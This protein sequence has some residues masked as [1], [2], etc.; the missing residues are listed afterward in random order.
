MEK[1]KRKRLN[2]C[3]D[4][5]AASTTIEA[6]APDS[7]GLGLVIP[8]P[9]HHERIIT[10]EYWGDT[11]PHA[12]SISENSAASGNPSEMPRLNSP[13]SRHEPK[14]TTE[15]SLS[16]KRKRKSDKD[17]AIYSQTSKR[18]K[19]VAAESSPSQK[20]KRKSDEDGTIYSHLKDRNSEW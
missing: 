9:G 4:S 13:S 6:A 19:Q 20:R 3:S 7:T 1:K 12:T 15:S 17:D 18:T 2:N 11:S 5:V 8:E 14:A 10:L 16:Q